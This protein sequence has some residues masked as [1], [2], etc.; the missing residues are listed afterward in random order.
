ME[1]GDYIRMTSTS[2]S[3]TPP[4][5]LTGCLNDSR[6]TQNT[7]NPSELNLWRVIRKNED[8]TIDVVSEYVSST[9]VAFYG[10]TGYINYIKGL[11][12]VASQYINEKY[13]INTRHIGY[14]NQ[15]EILIDTN[16]LDQTTLPW[17]KFTSIESQWTGCAANNY[18]C[19]T[20]EKLGAGDIGYEEDYKLVNGVY[21][22]M[23][24]R[25]PNGV[26]TSYWLA[27]RFY[28]TASNHNWLFDG[29][30][31]ETN[32]SLKSNWIYYYY[33]NLPNHSEQKYAIRP[34]LTIKS[35]IGIDSGDGT[36]T[37]PYEL[38]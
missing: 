9:N 15:I 38:S 27:S 32:G 10:K 33:Y 35:T 2:T 6:C 22:T 3:Y 5:D 17:T 36:N 16:M 30:F 21:G 14:S 34:I 12:E 1:L 20:D 11:N 31:V 37:S 23:V 13:V 18:L 25:T 28:W 7:I 29:R 19:G 8:G 26:A 24:G 4:S